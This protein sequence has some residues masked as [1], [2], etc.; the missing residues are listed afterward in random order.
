MPHYHITGRPHGLPAPTRPTARGRRP[1][2]NQMTC[3]VA[4]NTLL[5]SQTTTTPARK[6]A[7]TL[8]PA[9]PRGSKE[10]TYTYPAN[11]ANPP[12]TNT[13]K[14]LQ[15][16]HHPRR[17][18]NHP[19]HQPNTNQTPTRHQPKPPKHPK[20]TQQTPNTRRVTP[21]QPHTTTP[22]AHQPHAHQGAESSPRTPTIAENAPPFPRNNF[23]GETPSPP[24]A[25]RCGK[26]AWN[27][28]HRGSW[29]NILTTKHQSSKNPACRTHN[30]PSWR[31]ILTMRR[32][33]APSRARA[34][35]TGASWRQII[36]TKPLIH[37]QEADAFSA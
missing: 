19:K 21:P 26:R 14:P 18:A 9:A 4:Q 6:P 24:T 23:H 5:S 8:R 22:H 20:T 34:T 28:R 17:V 33:S 25:H 37:H 2:G 12:P 30:Q 32:F 11:N 16:S 1:A 35:K 36:A 29:L 13:P 3:K 31:K 7:G 27:R 10:E 15:T